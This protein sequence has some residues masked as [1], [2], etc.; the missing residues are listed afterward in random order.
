MPNITSGDLPWQLQ[1][2]LVPLETSRLHV[3]IMGPL[4]GAFEILKYFVSSLTFT[5]SRAFVRG[6]KTQ[7]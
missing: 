3:S 4:A 7:T 5:L 6:I 1:E 2:R